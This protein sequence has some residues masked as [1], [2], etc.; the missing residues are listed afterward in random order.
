MAKLQDIVAEYRDTKSNKV[1]YFWDDSLKGLGIKLNPSGNHKWVMNKSQNGKRTYSTIGNISLPYKV[2]MTAYM[3]ALY[4]TGIA[5]LIAENKKEKNIPTISKMIEIYM[6]REGSKK[7]SAVCIKSALK[8]GEKYLPKE[9]LISQLNITDLENLREKFESK[10][11]FNQTIAFLKVLWDR[12]VAWG[13]IPL[14]KNLIP[15]NPCKFIKRYK[16]YPRQSYLTAPEMRA[17]WSAAQDCSSPNAKGIVSL[18]LLTG[19][20]SK[21]ISG[22]KWS[23]IDFVKNK[24]TLYN[25]KNK[26]DHPIRLNDTM[27]EVIASMPQTSEYLFPSPKGDKPMRDISFSYTRMKEMAGV[28]Q[29]KTIHDLRRS[30]AT[31]LLSLK[32]GTK[33]ED[34]AR[35][36]NQTPEVCLRHYAI[37][38][39]DNKASALQK[40]PDLYESVL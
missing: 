13:H 17:M 30:V 16:I 11:S 39:D 18:I 35:A 20:R 8:A 40:L 23:D 14:E 2:A 29:D 27:R 25:T 37:S 4:D 36:L 21:E 9:L 22:L 33:I 38:L 7:A 6:E 24:M 32:D 12:A 5:N 15:S 26:N 28:S 34:I 19:G 1:E 31:Y 10:C 3:K